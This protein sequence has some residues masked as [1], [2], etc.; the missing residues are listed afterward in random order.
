MTMTYE[1]ISDRI[2]DRR[3]KRNDIAIMYA[4]AMLEAPLHT[5]DWP[6]INNAIIERWSVSGL[7]YIKHRAWKIAEN[8]EKQIEGMSGVMTEPDTAPPERSAAGACRTWFYV[9]CD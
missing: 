8:V 9:R 2:N 3:L 4:H 1:Q 5:T 6:S 7:D